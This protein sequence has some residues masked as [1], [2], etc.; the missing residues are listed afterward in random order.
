MNTLLKK[1]KKNLILLSVILIGVESALVLVPLLMNGGLP[2]EGMGSVIGSILG[3]LAGVTAVTMLIVCMAVLHPLKKSLISYEQEYHDSFDTEYPERRRIGKTNLYL[4]KNY[5]CM[6]NWANAIVVH[7]KDIVS[8]DLQHKVNTYTPLLK[9]LTIHRKDNAKA[10][11]LQFYASADLDVLGMLND[12]LNEGVEGYICSADQ[13]VQID[14]AVLAAQKAQQKAENKGAWKLTIVMSAV[15]AV[16]IGGMWYFKG[17]KEAAAAKAETAS[18]SDYYDQVVKEIRDNGSYDTREEYLAYVS[19]AT[20]ADLDQIHLTYS[21]GENKFYIVAENQSEYLFTGSVNLYDESNN[22]SDELDYWMIR[23]QD[24]GYDT[25]TKFTEDYSY[26]LSDSAFLKLDYENPDFSYDASYDWNDSNMWTNIQMDAADLTQEHLET[27]AKRYYAMDV[28][29]DVQS[30]DGIYFYDRTL[31]KE[32][33]NG[34]PDTS[35]ASYGALLEFSTKTITIY[36]L[37]GG[38]STN[39]ATIP[40][41]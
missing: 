41:K 16:L 30:Q 13:T 9:E 24:T 38:T 22:Y 4:T 31:V 21:T 10:K 2:K 29:A 34:Y 28:L 27:L 32:D 19:E 5:L 15:I 35:S 12:W 17:R 18:S 1:T 26:E 3:I 37:S 23:P 39:I 14:P 8:F 20:D 11:K 33:D 6:I 36:S 40:M 7:K 25:V